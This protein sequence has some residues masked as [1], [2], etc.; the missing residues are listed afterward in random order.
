MLFE[1]RIAAMVGPSPGQAE[2]TPLARPPSHYSENFCLLGPYRE[3]FYSPFRSSWY[4][5]RSEVKRRGPYE[6]GSNAEQREQR[7]PPE[8]H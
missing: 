3:V 2:P 5:S 8:R 1:W 4:T 6:G 7:K